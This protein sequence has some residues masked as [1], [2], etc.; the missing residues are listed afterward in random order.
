VSIGIHSWTDFNLRIPA[1]FMILTAVLAI[2][3]CALHLK[4]ERRHDVMTYALHKSPLRRGGTVIL[5]LL[6][7]LILWTGWGLFRHFVAEAYCTTEANPSL[8]LNP[9]PPIGRIERA[10]VWDGANAA[11]HYKMATLL[12]KEEDR[13]AQRQAQI[14]GDEREKAVSRDDLQRRT[15][16]ALEE[17]IRLNPLNAEY[18]TRLA[19]EYTHLWYR[20]D[21]VK[22]W[23]PAADISMERA[24]HVAGDWA[25]NPHLHLDMGNYWTMRSRSLPPEDP[26]VDIAWT[27]AL[28]HY[29]KGL[30]MN[31]DK[32]AKE[33]ITQFVKN[34]YPDETKIKE[35]LNEVKNE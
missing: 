11:Y 8:N 10:I 14:P 31:G 7:A 17:A 12:T 1:N 26:Q 4:E 24:S 15:I 23:L 32:K 5:V 34:F 18:H 27:K 16:D 21:Y 30:A 29:H 3:F 2:G 33:E 13:E 9:L 6:I 35:A 28:W 20:A 25:E 22:K 19:W